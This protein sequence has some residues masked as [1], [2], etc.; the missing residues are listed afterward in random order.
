MPDFHIICSKTSICSSVQLQFPLP[1]LSLGHENI[2]QKHENFMSHNI[3]KPNPFDDFYIEFFKKIASS[4][5]RRVVPL[6]KNLAK[7]ST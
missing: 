2:D 5:F 3:S 6:Q 4:L 7:I 1:G